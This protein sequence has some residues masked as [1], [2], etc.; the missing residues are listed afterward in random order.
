[1]TLLSF[2]CRDF[3][4]LA[5]AAMDPDPRYNLIYGPN[6][7]GK[8]SVLEAM[9]YLGRGKSFRS[10]PADRLVRHGAEEFV[11]VGRVAQGG[12]ALSLGVQNGRTGL[13]V[14]VGGDRR[15]GVAELAE[16]L[17]LQIVDPEVHD[18]VA[19]GPEERRRYLDWIA[20]HVEPTFLEQW[21][22][23]RRALKQRNAA[24]RDAAPAP[25]LAGWDRE[26]TEAALRVHEARRR[27]LALA[28]PVLRATAGE[29]LGSGIAFEYQQGWAAD[30]T[31]PQALAR[32]LERDRQLGSSRSGPQRADLRLSYDDRQARKLVSRGQQKLLAC[33]L[34]LGATEVVQR[35]LGR[36]L[37]L[38]LDDPAAELD[39][40]SLG[41]LMTAVTALGCQVVATALQPDRPLFPSPP[42]TFHV[43]QGRLRQV[44]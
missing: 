29:L 4:C 13:E 36:A 19:G 16:V 11:L 23:F 37:L 27:C 39:E 1:M 43:E 15:G 34:I 26:F 21:R 7:S 25:E 30:E 3:R 2:S 20:F 6:A 24:L 5:E 18:L 41:R 28:E 42:R 44:E 32:G 38:L 17:P 33:T 14:S 9:A 31:L 8:T 10:A 40:A 22:R 35:H 12:R